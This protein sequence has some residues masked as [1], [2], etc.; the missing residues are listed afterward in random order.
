MSDT[1][2]TPY[3]ALGIVQGDAFRDGTFLG[4][5]RMYM[6][7]VLGELAYGIHVVHEILKKGKA[8][9]DELDPELMKSVFILHDIGRPRTNDKEGPDIHEYETGER[10]RELNYPRIAG[11]AQTHFVSWEKTNEVLVPGGFNINPD[12]YIQDTLPS[13]VLTYADLSVGSDGSFVGWREKID[14]LVAKYSNS[15]RARPEMVKI[16]EAGGLER[17]KELCAQIETDYL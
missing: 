16:L 6:D 14:T 3:G 8:K 10:L 13:K 7:H 17:M 11:I 1:A 2:L 9:V 15:E 4:K 12:E 5:P